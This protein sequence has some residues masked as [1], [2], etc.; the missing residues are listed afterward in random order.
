MLRMNR[1]FSTVV[2]SL[3]LG[4]AYWLH[5][6]TTAAQ[7]DKPTEA[8]QQTLQEDITRIKT[9]VEAIK[10]ELV[11]IRKLLMQRPAGIAQPQTASKVGIVGSPMLGNKEAPVTLVEF[12]DYQCPF[13]GKFFANVLPALKS[14][15]IDTGKVRYVFRDFPLQQIHPY[16]RKAHEAAHCAGDQGKYWEMHELLFQNQQSLEVDMLK[17]FGNRLNLEPT[18]FEACLDTGKYAAEV[19]RNIKDGSGAGVRGTPGFFIGKSGPGE[20]TEAI[21]IS[22]VQPLEVYRNAIERLLGGEV[23]DK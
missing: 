6:G 20:T 9:D 8:A 17:Q 2:V 5:S 12:S 15:Y 3:V 16:A 22:G 1:P 19:D 18:G 4:A 13:C 14:E 21:Y 23:A 11:E 7:S 10:K